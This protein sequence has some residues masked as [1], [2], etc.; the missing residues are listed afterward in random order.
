MG[1]FWVVVVGGDDEWVIAGGHWVG[2]WEFKLIV[3]ERDFHV[4]YLRILVVVH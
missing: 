1:L 3:G 4:R 2:L